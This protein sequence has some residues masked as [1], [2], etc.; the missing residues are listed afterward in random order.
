MEN[1]T[2]ISLDNDN[3]KENDIREDVSEDK[4]ANISTVSPDSSV[5][6]KSNNIINER[7]GISISVNSLFA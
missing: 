5:K 4:F 2:N 6:E 7:M 1:E 3:T